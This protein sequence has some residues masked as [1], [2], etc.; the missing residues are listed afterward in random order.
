M[1]QRNLGKT[2]LRVSVLGFGGAEIGFNEVASQDVSRML[3]AALDAGLNL[4]D[5]AAAYVKSEALIGE[6]VSHRRQEYLLVTK[7]GALDGFSRSDWSKEGILRTVET[8]LRNLRTDHVDVLL[9]HSCSEPEMNWGEAVTGVEAARDKGYARFIGYSGDG[10]PAL[11]AVRSGRFDVLETSISIAD[12]EALELTLPIAREKNLGVIAK[13]PIA[14]AAWRYKEAP[15]NSYHTEYWRRLQKLD[16]DF[17]RDPHGASSTALRFTLSQPGVSCAI[18]GTTNAERY[19]QNAAAIQQGPLPQS[20][21]DAIRT[22]WAET[23]E[24]S[25]V[26]MI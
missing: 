7:C 1:E 21:I 6:A 14:N 23:A 10:G 17:L 13:R 25:W 11:W 9:L 19:Q 15:S 26:G 16:Y 4:I 2:G 8:S 3:N 5:T 24:N 18:V 20:D 12:Q 22:R